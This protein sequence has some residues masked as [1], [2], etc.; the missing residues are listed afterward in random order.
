MPVREADRAR[1]V[2]ARK[3][4]NRVIGTVREQSEGRVRRSKCARSLSGEH[5]DTVD[6]RATLLAR[7]LPRLHLVRS[8]PIDKLEGVGPTRAKR[9]RSARPADARRSARILPARLPAANSPRATIVAAQAGPDPHRAR[10]GRRGRLHSR[11]A[12]GRASK[13]R[14]TTERHKLGARL[15]Q[16]AP[17][18]A[19][20]FTPA[21]YIR[22]RGRGEV[23]PQHAADGQPE[24]G[25]RSKPT[26]PQVGESTF[27]AIYPAIGET[28]PASDRPDHRRA[29]ST[30]RC[31]TCEEWFDPTLLASSTL[32]DR[33]RDAYRT[34][35][36]P[37]RISSEA[38]AGPAAASSTT[39]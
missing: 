13:R 7:R 12:R 28:C 26:T 23:L 14:S 20:R 19:T 17:T 22:V 1:R 10:R 36:P 15:V 3:R 31:R 4:S 5:P 33:R 24:V 9:A 30:T 35:P 25:D 16:R 32:L 38:T 18:C 29:T 21:I 8:I 34:D 11:A 39:S 37:R 27:R 6:L 2:G